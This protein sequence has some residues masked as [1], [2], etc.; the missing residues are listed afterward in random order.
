MPVFC[1]SN[2]AELGQA[3]SGLWVAGHRLILVLT[4]INWLLLWLGASWNFK[5]VHNVVFQLSTHIAF[6]SFEKKKKI[7]VFQVHGQINRSDILML[8]WCLLLHIK[9]FL[10]TNVWVTLRKCC[11]MMNMGWSFVGTSFRKIFSLSYILISTPFEPHAFWIIMS[12]NIPLKKK[13]EKRKKMSIKTLCCNDGL[14][15]SKCNYVP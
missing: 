1:R 8:I 7:V 14:F 11:I 9:E 15:T 5:P 12:I 3:W 10:G 13:G 2:L 6:V 4:G